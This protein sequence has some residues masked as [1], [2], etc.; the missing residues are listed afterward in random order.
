MIKNLGFYSG[1][2]SGKT[3]CILWLQDLVTSDVLPPVMLE[4]ADAF[5]SRF[6]VAVPSVFHRD[7][8]LPAHLAPFARVMMNGIDS[9]LVSEAAAIVKDTARSRNRS[10]V[11][12]LCKVRRTLTLIY[13]RYDLHNEILPCAVLLF[14][15]IVCLSAPNRGLEQ[16]LDMWPL[17]REA[18]PDAILQVK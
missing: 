7:A 12:D 6:F 8:H 4:L 9:A 16:V 11:V 13:A 2:D 18:H 1:S 14:I 15:F 10:L 3:T 5:R 17:I